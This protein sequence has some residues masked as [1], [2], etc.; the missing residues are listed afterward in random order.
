M[1]KKHNPCSPSELLDHLSLLR[2]ILL[3]YAFVIIKISYSCW[4]LEESE[5]I[6]VKAVLIYLLNFN[7][8]A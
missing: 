3:L 4:D 1:I 5:S 6:L 2:I 8:S 7:V